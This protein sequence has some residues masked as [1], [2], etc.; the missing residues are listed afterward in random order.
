MIER[1]EAWEVTEISD[2]RPEAWV[3]DERSD[4]PLE[5]V[6]KDIRNCVRGII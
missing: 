1:E 4:A 6:Y 5:G 2:E 3:D